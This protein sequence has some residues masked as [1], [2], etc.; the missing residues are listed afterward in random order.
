MTQQQFSLYSS[1]V[2]LVI[3]S[4][5]PDCQLTTLQKQKNCHGIVHSVACR[6][7][8]TSAFSPRWWNNAISNY[9]IHKTKCHKNCVPKNKNIKNDSDSESL[10]PTLKHSYTDMRHYASIK[11]MTQAHTLF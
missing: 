6:T 1:W 2:K 9:S 10:T 11:C 3:I 5:H 4:Q 7:V 8:N